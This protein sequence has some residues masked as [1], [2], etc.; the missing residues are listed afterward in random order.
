M[1][2]PHEYIRI[3]EYGNL[4]EITI[5]LP[6]DYI[7]PARRPRQDH[8]PPEEIEKI[9]EN[10][11]KVMNDTIMAAL[12]ACNGDI[13]AAA[14]KSRYTCQRIRDLLREKTRIAQQ[15]E[16]KTQIEEVRKLAAQKIPIAETAK[17]TGKSANTIRQWVK[18]ETTQKHYM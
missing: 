17:I 5:S 14:K 7:R 10:N 18:H 3:H 1:W 6:W 8:I 13:K 9:R 4:I 2:R 16:R 11:R 12:V 15:T